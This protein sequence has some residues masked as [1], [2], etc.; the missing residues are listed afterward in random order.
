MNEQDR[1]VIAFAC[2]ARA[3]LTDVFGKDPFRLTVLHRALREQ[4]LDVVVHA[5]DEQ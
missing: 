4:L 2:D 5:E 3:A 1:T